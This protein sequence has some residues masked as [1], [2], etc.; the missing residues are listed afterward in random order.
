[1]KTDRRLLDIYAALHNAFGPQQWWPA[2]TTDEV[3]IGAILAQNV[4]WSN[5][6]KAI[7]QLRARHLLRLSA[8]AETDPATIAP[9]I[10]PTRFYNQKADR[11][12][13]FTRLLY[14]DYQGNLDRMMNQSTDSLRKQLLSLKGF[15]EETADSILLYAGG[16]PVFVIDAYTRR[17][18]ARMGFTESDI[19][20]GRLQQFFMDRLPADPGLYNDYHAQLVRLGNTQCKKRSP[21]CTSCPVAD[22]C[23][24][25]I[26]F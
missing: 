14:N 12:K 18:C 23:R 21:A 20:Y 17:I 6:E 8:I 5:V 2:E 15:G 4:A 10:R 26:D 7:A 13:A 3:V 22:Y 9:L 1:M 19:S 11:L 24:Q 25:R 16:H